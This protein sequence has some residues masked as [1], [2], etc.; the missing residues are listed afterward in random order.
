[1]DDSAIWSVDQLAANNLAVS[2]GLQLTSDQ[3][4]RVAGHFSDHRRSACEWA[5]QRAHEKILEKMEADSMEMARRY[6]APWMDGFRRAEE[7][8]MTI[9]PDEL[10]DINPKPMVSKGQVLRQMVRQARKAH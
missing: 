3:I 10:A 4:R 5:I 8:V 7:L 2:L 9:S 1:M 6:D